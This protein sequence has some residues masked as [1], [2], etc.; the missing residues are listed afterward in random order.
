MIDNNHPLLLFSIN[1]VLCP[2]FSGWSAWLQRS[3]C[4]VPFLMSHDVILFII[5]HYS[6]TML[7]VLC[8][9]TLCTSSQIIIHS[10]PPFFLCCSPPIAQ[11]SCPFQE[12]PNI[13]IIDPTPL[14][15]QH[16]RLFGLPTTVIPAACFSCVQPSSPSSM[17]RGASLPHF[18]S[19]FLA[20]SLYSS[21]RQCHCGCVCGYMHASVCRSFKQHLANLCAACSIAHLKRKHTSFAFI[22]Q[23]PTLNIYNS[24]NAHCCNE[25]RLV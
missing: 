24:H 19:C 6:R 4:S 12:Y 25:S 17:T 10:F 8:T 16:S 20:L 15:Y 1:D 13:I 7:F 9:Q 22:V 3:Q 21:A 5:H 11:R 2:T 18:V 23:H 14:Q